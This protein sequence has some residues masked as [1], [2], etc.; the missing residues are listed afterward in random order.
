MIYGE[1]ESFNLDTR[2]ESF[3]ALTVLN[4]KVDISGDRWQFELG[5]FESLLIPAVCGEY[6]VEFLGTSHAL[7][8]FVP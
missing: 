4:G 1:K 8:A 7:K 6:R 3:S 2:G 5:R